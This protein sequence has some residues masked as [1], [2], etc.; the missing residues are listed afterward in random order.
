M[1]NLYVDSR[2]LGIFPKKQGHSFQ[3]PK[4]KRGVLPLLPDSLRLLTYFKIFL[5][6]SKNAPEVSRIYGSYFGW[7]VKYS[8]LRKI[9]FVNEPMENEEL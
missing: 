1:R 7:R 8:E 6:P 2:N 4:K 3:F 9:N 5:S